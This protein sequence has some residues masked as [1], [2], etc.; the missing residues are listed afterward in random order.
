MSFS[1]HS[2]MEYFCSSKRWSR[3]DRDM[4]PE[5]SSMGEISSKISSSPERSGT[6]SLPPALAAAT[7]ACQSSLPSNQSKLS[8]WSARRSGTSSGSRILAKLR[9]PEAVRAVDT[10]VFAVREAAKDGSF[11]RPYMSSGS[12]TPAQTTLKWDQTQQCESGPQLVGAAGTGQR[13]EIAYTKDRGGPTT[14]PSGDPR[15]CV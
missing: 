5:K 10:V 15:R 12:A 9:R 8:V 11:H 13:K 1:L 14:P 7:R 4:E 3:N 6:S 2:S